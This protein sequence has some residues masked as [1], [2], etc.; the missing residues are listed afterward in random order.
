[1]TEQQKKQGAGAWP[2]P[3]KPWKPIDPKRPTLA[4]I[5]N[6]LSRVEPVGA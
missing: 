1:M 6:A 3:T 5:R 2:K 4:E